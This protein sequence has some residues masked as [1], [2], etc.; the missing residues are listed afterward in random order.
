MTIQEK[1]Q[2]VRELVEGYY[3]A[4]SS[5]IPF[6]VDDR[7]HIVEIGTSILC[8]KWKVGYPGGGFVQAVVNNDLRGAFDRA[9]NT[10]SYALKFYCKLMFNVGMPSDLID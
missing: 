4:N 3:A 9:D 2:R 7:E 1:M 10:N 5:D 6:F 8:T